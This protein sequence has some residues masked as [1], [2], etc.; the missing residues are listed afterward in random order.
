[1]F[2]YE[3]NRHQ[4]KPKALMT[5]LC[6]LSKLWWYSAHQFSVQLLHTDDITEHKKGKWYITICAIRFIHEQDTLIRFLYCSIVY[7]KRKSIS[8]LIWQ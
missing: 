3:L 7:P 5:C 8:S 6:I 2:Y 1:M 4:K